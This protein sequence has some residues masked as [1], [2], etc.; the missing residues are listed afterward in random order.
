MTRATDPDIPAQTLRNL[1]DYNPKTGVLTNRV[2]RGYRA[3]AGDEAGTKTTRRPGPTYRVVSISRRKVRVHRVI[4]KLQ[5]GQWPDGEIDHIDGD[6]LNNRWTNLRVTGRSVN[7]ANKAHN[8]RD[9][10]SRAVGVSFHAKSRKW[11]AKLEFQGQRVLDTYHDAWGEALA[12]RR[13]AERLF[14]PEVTF[15]TTENTTHG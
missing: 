11:R 2:T 9:N 13:T 1:F 12:A 10:T 4:W 7:C 5:T 3:S 8:R 14:F 15:P 6:G